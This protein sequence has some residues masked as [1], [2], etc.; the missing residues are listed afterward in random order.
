VV[1]VEEEVGSL[2]LLKRQ[3]A[4]KLVSEEN[5]V[6]KRIFLMISASTF[7]IMLGAGIVVPILP[8][9]A[10]SFEASYLSVG[11]TISAFGLARI[12]TDIPSGT[13]SDRVGRRPSIL[14]GTTIFAASGLL[15]AY[16][17]SIKHLIAARFLQ[18]VGAA[19]YTTS[20]LAY[21]ADILPST[22]KGRYI[23]YY[24]SSFFLGSAFGP[25]LGG[26]LASIGGL[27][28]PFLALST[29]SLVSTLATYRGLVPS[30]SKVE[31]V[32]QQ[33]RIPS[34]ITAVLR[35]R[36]IIVSCVAAATTFILSTAIRFTLLPIYSEKI[37]NLSEVEVGLVLTLIA[38][39]NFLMMS[40]AG[41]I[42]DKFGAEATMIYGFMFS[43]LTTA[44]YALSFDL[45]TLLTVSCSFGVATSLIA[46]A[47]VS[48]VVEAS[49]PKHRGLSLGVY[50][51]FSDIGF[52][53]GPL[54]SGTL[55]EFLPITYA[56][57]SIACIS[58]CTAFFICLMRKRD[59]VS[60]STATS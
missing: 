38:L 24:Q 55:I 41:L 13:L 14:L 3:I 17:T 21:I 47:Q 28:L 37:L 50:R 5:S 9:Y 29:L 49:D 43:G 31:V 58:F 53:V 54:L 2:R 33:K 10:E 45:P 35:S 56:F 60:S 1:A 48:L 52:I 6:D 59:L 42:A 4:K 27:K 39:V 36:S 20:A 44:L 16:A 34:V 15:A 19:I 25:S 7:L 51:V 8:R 32:H 57:Y 46:P 26:L 11:F 30:A 18:G 23:G 40:R 22:R 12:I